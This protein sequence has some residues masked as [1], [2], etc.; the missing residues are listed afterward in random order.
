MNPVTDLDETIRYLKSEK[1]KLEH[2]IASLEALKR[3]VL[4]KVAL[5]TTRKRQGRK[6]MGAAER[7]EVSRRMKRYWA[8]RRKHG[9]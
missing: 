7:E 3:G 6:S 9:L 5:A 4:G 2:A 8:N 1:G